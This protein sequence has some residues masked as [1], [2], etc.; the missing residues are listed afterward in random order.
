MADIWIT[1]FASPWHESGGLILAS[2]LLTLILYVRHPA[3]RRT[4]LVW[5]FWLVLA[6]MLATLPFAAGSALAKIRNAALPFIAGLVVIRLLGLVFFR[7]FLPPFHLHPPRILQDILVTVVFVIWGMYQLRQAGLDLSQ[8]VVT[9]TVLTAMVAFAMQDTIGN[10]LA[11]LTLQWDASIEAGDWIKV[12][13][14]VGKVVD[15]TW[16]ATYLETRNGETVVLPNSMLTRNRFAILGKRQGKPLMWRR[17]VYFDVSLETLP[18]QI[19]GMVEVALLQGMLSNVSDSP[20]PQCILMEADKGVGRFAVRY[21]LTDLMHDDA[22]DSLVRT[23]ID[24][25]LRRNGRRFSPPQYNLLL[26]FDNKKYSE[27]RHKRHTEERLAVLRGLELLAPLNEDELLALSDRL[28]F[29]PFVRGETVLAQGADVDWLYIL[30]KGEMEQTIKTPD[31]EIHALGVLSAG[32]FFGEIA[33][34]TGVC[35]PIQITAMG[36]AECYR[37]DRATFQTLL[38][39][40]HELAEAFSLVLARRQAEYQQLISE[41]AKNGM[42]T[43]QPREMLARL[44]D[45]FGLPH[46]G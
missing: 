14:V 25:A 38:L 46:L 27:V 40:R 13:D 43:P 33:L 5:L 32:S 20:A 18:T 9:S 1:L 2:L 26:S 7:L 45:L 37:L 24:A 8:I 36:N 10:V 17:W 29:T 3:L 19:I 28:K 12:D 4:V 30:I 41:H 34:M 6:A 42:A 23:A 16:R 39:M 15:V 35:F 22:T 21:W 11:G 44:R 31:G